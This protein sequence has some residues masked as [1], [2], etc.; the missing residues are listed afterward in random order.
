MLR[1]MSLWILFALFTILSGCETVP[2]THRSQLMLLP[3]SEEINLGLQA[4]AQTLKQERVSNDPALNA[5]VRRVGKRIA[6]AAQ[7]PE[8]D[9]EFTVLES[10][11]V[12]AFCLPGGKVAVYTGLLKIT[13]SDA[14]LA[15]VMSHEVAHAL[16]R[17]GGERMSQ[18][19]LV[20]LGGVGLSAGLGGQNQVVREG[21]M[22][23]FGMGSQV[24]ILLP[25]SRKQE[26]EADHIGLI[27]M[28]KAGYDPRAAL[29]FW[30][31]MMKATKGQGKPPELL[32]THPS[33]ERRLTKIETEF[34]PE[35]LQYYNR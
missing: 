17:H 12:N 6:Q 35:A 15:T 2:Y 24:G 21:I 11:E 31:A 29:D 18:D 4:F 20:Q 26:E 22:Q 25:Y 3:E 33:D 16:A 30:R 34:L 9:W 8:Y 28:A 1:L 32:S 7:K 27:L 19:L 13:P 14:M 5:R 23:A 10:K